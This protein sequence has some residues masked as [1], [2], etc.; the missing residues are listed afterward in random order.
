MLHALPDG[1]QLELDLKIN[2]Q[3]AASPPPQGY[4]VDAGLVFGDRGGGLFYGW[5]LDNRR[6]TRD[7]NNPASPDQRYDTLTHTQSYGVRTWE[8]ALPNGEYSVR[9]VAGD[10][11]AYDSVYALNAEVVLVTSG[12]ATGSRHWFDG[13]QT[14]VVAD[15]RL[16]VSNAPGSRNNKIAFIEVK[17]IHSEP[18]T[19]VTVV[20]SDASAAEAG[21][22]RG[23]FVISRV[24]DTDE[25]LAVQYTLGGTARNGVD[26]Y[27]MVSQVT[28]ASGQSSVAIPVSP[29]LDGLVEGNETVSLTLVGGADYAVATPD[30][31]VVTIADADAQPPAPA[32]AEWRTHAPSPV[33]RFESGSAS[34]GGKLYVFGGYDKNIL[35]F[36]RSDV[37]DPAAD[38]WSRIADMPQAIT[39][40]GVA[41]DGPLVYFAGGFVGER[42][43]EITA[44]VWRYDTRNNT[45][46]A[47]T[48]LPAARA[49]GGLVRV[50]RTLHFFGGTD[51]RLARDFGD[52]WV[53]DLDAAPG[54]AGASW[55]PLAPLP[56]PRNHVGYAT[57]GGKVYC[58]G[59]QLLG[60]EKAGNVS[61]VHAYDPATNRWTA[62]ARLPFPLSH[63]HTSTVVLGGRIVTVGGK[64]NDPYFPKTIGDVLSYDPASKTWVALP[65]LPD[66]RQAAVAQLIGDRLYVTTGTPRGIN[67]QPQTWSRQMTNAWDAAAAMPVA[68]GE[69][70]GGVIGGKLYLVGEGS[71]ATL[72]YDLT[73]GTWSNDTALARR[74]YRGN[75]HAAEVVNG[76]LYL[77]GGLGGSSEGKV[78]V[79]DPAANRWTLG[80]SMPFAAG[81]SSSAV[82]GGKVYVAG[83][84]VG[85]S[86]TSR[87]A[88]YDPATNS[89]T[90]LAPMPAGRNHAA[91]G[92][93]GRKLYVFGG[94]GPGSGDS[95]TVANGFDTV[96]VY[97][98]AINRWTSSATPGS[99]IRPLPQAR[100]GGGKAVFANGEFHVI[101]G[102]TFDGPGATPNRVYHRV[103]VYNPTTNTWRLGPSMPTARHGIFPLLFANRVYV[104]GG[105]TRAG[106]STSAVL[107]VLNLP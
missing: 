78:Q 8:L 80:A 47:A 100:G 92:T 21:T 59:G 17:S 46:S 93:D 42:S 95:N 14:V 25:P 55:R 107:E 4:L 99:T 29:L 10:P 19:T 75:H 43:F 83:G 22:D 102:E 66:V 86:T 91:A 40:A 54:T 103:D 35:A 44:N 16:T 13:T 33:A 81:S 31:A 76:K 64:T 28:F 63:T 32:P 82:I 67:P 94:R 9:I 87:V 18:G 50:G 11:S 84:I 34:I 24:G 3:P 6:A 104:A 101:G 97:D 53:L 77:F 85:S 2:F 1:S 57:V 62:V 41:T 20:A 52:H 65:P 27:P 26:Y 70:A 5:D 56:T 98:P 23:T 61:D 71:A 30:G 96:Q 58:I 45:W 105:G 90:E 51:A 7:R 88:R 38:R 89:W 73:T 79:Y 39:H 37:Y 48:P 12:R 68:M 49:A 106:A 36:T 74:A 72:A 60:D 15:G 69:V